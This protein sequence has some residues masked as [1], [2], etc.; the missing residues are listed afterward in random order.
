MWSRMGKAPWTLVQAIG[1]RVNVA[2][3]MASARAASSGEGKSVSAW[4][5]TGRSARACAFT[6]ASMTIA[7]SSMRASRQMATLIPR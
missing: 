3:A 5:V 7:A 4:T 6:E 1:T 2:S